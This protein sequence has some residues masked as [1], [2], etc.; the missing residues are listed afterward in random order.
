MKRICAVYRSTRTEGM[1][2]YVD[3]Q[4]DVSRVPEDLLARFGKLERAMTLV[5]TKER[6]L[7]RADVQKVMDEIVDKGFYLQLPPQAERLN[8]RVVPEIDD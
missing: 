6:K 5:L 3:H 8:P 7:A 4:E 1:Y 2:L